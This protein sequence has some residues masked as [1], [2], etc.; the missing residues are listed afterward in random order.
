M[1]WPTTG[2]VKKF[3]VEGKP[4]IPVTGFSGERG[5]TYGD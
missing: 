4:G 3:F 1:T 2:F 5:T